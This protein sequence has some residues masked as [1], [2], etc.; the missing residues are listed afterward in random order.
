M[1]KLS[2]KVIFFS[3]VE[4]HCLQLQNA[5]KHILTTIEFQNFLGEHAPGPPLEGKALQALPILCPGVKVSCPP[6]QNLNEPP[7]DCGK[8]C[9]IVSVILT[10]LFS[11]AVIIYMSR[12]RQGT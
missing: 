8:F 5:G 11:S 7:D 2:R 3:V 4:S 10:S 12:N 9:A 6:V 1:I